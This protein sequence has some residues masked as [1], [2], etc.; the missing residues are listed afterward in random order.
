LAGFETFAVVAARGDTP[1]LFAA[2]ERPTG[3]RST[4]SKERVA[5]IEKYLAGSCQRRGLLDVWLDAY[6]AHAAQ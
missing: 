1:R 2:Y 6:A 5:R 4:A 3:A